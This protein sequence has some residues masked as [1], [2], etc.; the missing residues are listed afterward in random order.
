M[1][2][3]VYRICVLLSQVL[4]RV[5]MGT[6][7]GLLHPLFALLSGRFL[8]ARGAVFPALAALG[9][10]T[11]VVRRSEAALC[12]GC[13][14]TADLLTGW[15]QAVA[16]EGR[17]VPCEYEGIRPVACDLT[18]FFR[19]HLRGLGALVFGLGALVF[20]LGAL[21]FGLGAAVGH[22]GRTRLGLPR[23][24]PR[25]GLPRLL[26]RLGLPRLLPRLLLR[27]LLR[28]KPGEREADL[29]HARLICN[30]RG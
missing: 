17:F 23:L 30:T 29:Q 15:Q 7:L 12:Y 24:L 1:S 28:R 16:Q 27:L 3:R 19:P 5:P 10:P 26:P 18:A 20:G 14:D 4:S 11:E 2:P 13:W 8:P 22:V 6:N 21:V 9:L 25:L